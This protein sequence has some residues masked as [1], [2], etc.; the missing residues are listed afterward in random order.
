[1]IADPPPMIDASAFFGEWPYW[2]LPNAGD[3]EAGLLATLDRW[4]IASAAVSST[5]A[6][7]L[8]GRAGND[9]VLALARRHPS[10]LVP[11]ATVNPAI[12]DEAVEDAEAS[13][14]GG[15]RAIRLAPAY[16]GYDLGP[17]RYLDAVVGRARSAVVPLVLTLRA[18][19]NWGFPHLP[20]GELAPWL[21]R[22]PGLR[23]VL[24]GVNRVDFGA[25]VD[26]ARSADVSLETSCLQEFGAVRAAVDRLGADRVLLGTGLPLQYAACGVAKVLNAQLDEGERRQVLGANA[27]A[28]FG[29]GDRYAAPGSGK[30]TS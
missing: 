20:A 1:M 26:L 14:A 21:S 4:Q 29:I 3:G 25:A 27:A 16:H 8:D 18:L 28:L 23:L 10:R 30:V 6:L 9:E 12:G 11:L 7:L 2:R 24:A 19:M 5:K 22:F 15:A 13:L 17:N